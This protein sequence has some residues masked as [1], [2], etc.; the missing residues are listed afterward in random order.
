MFRSCCTRGKWTRWCPPAVLREAAPLFN[1]ARVA[2]QPG[3]GHFPWVDDP[4][5][6]AATIGSFLD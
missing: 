6:F 1:D 2:V 3:A 5:A 4:W